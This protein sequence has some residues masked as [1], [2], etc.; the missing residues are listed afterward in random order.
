MTQK[1]KHTQGP[2][3][4]DLR[5]HNGHCGISINAPNDIQ[6]ATVYLNIIDTAWKHPIVRPQNNESVR[7]ARQIAAAPD[8][9][10]ALKR[11]E[12]FMHDNYTREEMSFWDDTI[13]AIA[14]AE[15]K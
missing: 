1:A 9:Y 4:A 6:V 2:W 15:G 12:R 7:N 3:K 10:E 8:L 11:W 13:N 5:R 14:K